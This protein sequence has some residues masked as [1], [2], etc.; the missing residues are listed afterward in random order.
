VCVRMV[1]VITCQ[2]NVPVLCSVI[3]SV[4]FLKGA[5]SQDY[6]L[7]MQSPH[8]LLVGVSVLYIYASDNV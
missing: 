2:S 4:Y 6:A 5:A 8:N 3:A 1:S 7:Y